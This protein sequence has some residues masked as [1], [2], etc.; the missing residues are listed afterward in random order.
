[1]KDK[2]T[3]LV[4]NTQERSLCFFV[5]HVSV[6]TLN[7]IYVGGKHVLSVIKRMIISDLGDHLPTQMLGFGN[8]S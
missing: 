5:F 4:K 8:G 3:C 2:Y 6:K 7:N 1:M